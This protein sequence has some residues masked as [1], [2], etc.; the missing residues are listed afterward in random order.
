MICSTVNQRQSSFMCC[1]KMCRC[2]IGVGR[3]HFRKWYFF[4]H[5]RFYWMCPLPLRQPQDKE[6]FWCLLLQ[7]PVLG[8]KLDCKGKSEP[9]VV[10]SGLWQKFYNNPCSIWRFSSLQVVRKLYDKIFL[11]GWFWTLVF[12]SLP[13][14]CSYDIAITVVSDCNFFSKIDYGLT[15]KY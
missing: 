2:E 6:L 9:L 5:F 12:L 8:T 7:G 10:I 13:P 1:R 15:E 4:S 3:C 11:S 14:T